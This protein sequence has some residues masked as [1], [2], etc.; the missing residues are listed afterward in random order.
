MTARLEIEPALARLIERLRYRRL[1]IDR[2]TID[3]LRDFGTECLD[4]GMQTAHS[5]STIPAPIGHYSI[6]FDD[7]EKDPSK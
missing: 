4:V 3:A 6:R 5:K 1:H 2:I 7:S